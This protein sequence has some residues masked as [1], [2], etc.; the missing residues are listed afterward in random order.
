MDMI[1]GVKDS[2]GTICVKDSDFF[3]QS[4]SPKLDNFVVYRSQDV[5][6][7]QDL[8]A[9]DHLNL[10]AHLRGNQKFGHV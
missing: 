5:I 1:L 3:A 7:D 8:N 9:A 10:F 6:L 2:C 4:R